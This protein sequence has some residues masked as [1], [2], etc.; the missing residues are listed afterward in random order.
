MRTNIF[1]D[2]ELLKE[3]F[4]LSKARTK[5]ELIHLALE[6]FVQNRRRKDLR[7]LKGRIRFFE[8]YDYNKMREQ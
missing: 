1:L 6:E 3:A 8:G 4:R 7:E 5:K 2:D